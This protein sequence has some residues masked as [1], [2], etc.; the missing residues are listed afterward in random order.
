MEEDKPRKASVSNTSTNGK[1]FEK[2]VGY[3]LEKLLA[4]V[5]SKEAFRESIKTPMDNIAK[6][7][8]RMDI[9]GRPME[10]VP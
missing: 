4:F 2:V 3:S 10:V 9:G 8:G 7:Y 6:R 1:C 5:L